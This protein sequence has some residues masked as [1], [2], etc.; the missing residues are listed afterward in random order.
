MRRMLCGHSLDLD[1]LFTGAETL[2]RLQTLGH[3]SQRRKVYALP[4][5]EVRYGQSDVLPKE[6]TESCRNGVVH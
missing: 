1:R 5:H 4:T 3:Q 2:M 6:D